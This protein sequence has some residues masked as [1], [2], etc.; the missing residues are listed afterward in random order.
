M[1][2]LLAWDAV[3]VLADQVALA[4]A[5]DS[6]EFLYFARVVVEVVVDCER[7]L[8]SFVADKRALVVASLSVV[9]V[10][11]RAH[12]AVAV[13]GAVLGD[14]DVFV[15]VAVAAVA[16]V[17]VV[18]PAEAVVHVLAVVVVVAEEFFLEGMH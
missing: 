13:A 15:L 8:N 18:V 14:V 12:A 11:A 9:P 3:V 10:V 17:A 5:V 4:D 16:D 7:A 2:W 6:V 1:H